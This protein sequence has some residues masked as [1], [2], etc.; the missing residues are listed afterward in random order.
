MPRI[1]TLKPEHRQ[2]RKIGPL[3][4]RQYRLWV[5]MICDADDYGRLVA[6]PEQLRVT[7]WGYHRK[8]KAEQVAADLASLHDL[9]LVVLYRVDAVLY[10]SFPSWKDHQKVDHPTDSRLPEPIRDD[11]RALA[12]IRGGSEGIGRDRKEGKGPEATPLLATL[13]LAPTNGHVQFHTPDVILK[14]LTRAPKLGAVLKLATPEFWQAELRA[15]PGVDY[16]AE[17]LKAEAY[18]TSHPERHYKK[19]AGFLHNW[20]ARAD[21]L[22]A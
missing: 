5:G 13:A 14:A 11:S 6:E 3:T 20:L 16:P 15:N 21:R 7:I 22:E 12:S 9:G 17:I 1:R 19:L 10:A 8:V 18:L 4:D 2:H